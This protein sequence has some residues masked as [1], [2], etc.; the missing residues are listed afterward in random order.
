LIMANRLW[1]RTHTSEKIKF[2]GN[3]ETLVDLG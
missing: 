2:N 3:N 1:S